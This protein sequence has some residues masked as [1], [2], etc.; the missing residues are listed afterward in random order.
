[1]QQAPCHMQQ[2]PCNMQQKPCSG[3]RA[4]DDAH[5]QAARSAC[6]AHPAELQLAAPTYESVHAGAS[7]APECTRGA[8]G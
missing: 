2:T 8:Q 3:K 4:T 7:Q 6:T 5:S 1:V